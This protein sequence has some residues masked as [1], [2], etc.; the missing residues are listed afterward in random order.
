MTIMAESHLVTEWRAARDNLIS[1]DRSLR[2]DQHRSAL[3]SQE[4]K[5]DTIIRAI[6]K[7]EAEGIWSTQHDS[8]LNPFPGM[9]FLTGKKIIEQ[10]T[11]FD[12]LLKM[13]KGGLLHAHLDATVDARTLLQLALETPGM[14]VRIADMFDPATLTSNVPEFR[15]LPEAEYTTQSSIDSAP[16]STWVPVTAAR[17]NFPVD[18]AAG[19]DKWALGAMMINPSE[20]YGT[21]NTLKKIWQKFMSTFRATHGLF[22]HL[23]IFEKYVRKALLSSVEDGI[24]YVEP[25]VNFLAKFMTGADGQENV[26]HR[27]WLLVF[28][29]VLRDVKNELKN[30]GRADELFGARIIYSTVRFITPDELKWYLQDCIAMKK[31]FPHLIAGFD[32]VGDENV[33]HPLKYYAE[34]LLQFPAMQDAAGLPEDQRIP[35]IFHAGETLGDGSEA[36]DN[37]YDAVLLGTKRIGHGFSIVKHPKIM[38]LCRERG[39]CVEVCPISNEIL[40]LTSSMPMH[41]LPI[42]LNNGLPVALCSD[43]PAVFGSMGL[44]YDYFQVLASS[45]LSGLMT[46]GELAQD[47]IKFSCLGDEDKQIALTAWQRRWE[48]F[49]DMIVENYG[50]EIA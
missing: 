9:E 38:E 41:P 4:E 24:S 26:P 39:I 19:F 42:M 23:P 40:R 29:R 34:V 18:G 43:D 50:G 33:L 49:I 13:P 48:A 16:S 47:S 2:R 1:A 21:H 6:R 14:H 5:A 15:V 20:A 17:G 11:L 32:L 3:S 25:R 22:F 44:S 12:I 27:D 36:D 35:F 28:D 45:D 37:L 30:Q 31:E 7:K 8:I 46:L 10:T